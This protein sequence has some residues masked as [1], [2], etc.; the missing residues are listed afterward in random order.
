[1]TPRR[2]FATEIPTGTVVA[3]V[4]LDGVA[5]ARAAT[6]HLKGE[7]P[8][9]LIH[10]TPG[11]GSSDW[12]GPRTIS[13][14]ALFVLVASGT[15]VGACSSSS[16]PA[17]APPDGEDASG[18]ASVIPPPGAAG[19]DASGFLDLGFYPSNIGCGLTESAL[20]AF[21][22]DAGIDLSMLSDVDITN[23]NINGSLDSDA[24]SASVT[25][26]HSMD[27]VA[28]VKMR[29]SNGTI[30]GIYI[31]NSW[32]IEAGATL[33]ITGSS[34]IALVALTDIVVYGSVDVECGG[35]ATGSSGQGQ[36]PGGGAASSNSGTN[37][38]AGGGSFCGTGG[39]GGGSTAN[40]SAYGTGPLVPLLGGSAGGSGIDGGA[41]GGA[42][43]FV[44]GTTITVSGSI[45]APG[46]PG[47][48]GGAGG[49]SGGALLLEAPAV[50][51]SG[52]LATNG[53]GGGSNYDNGGMGGQAGATPAQ[54]GG[55]GSGASGGNGSAAATIAGSPG[56]VN[57]GDV[58]G[59]GGGAGHIRINTM[60]GVATLTGGTLSPSVGTVCVSQGTLSSSAPSCN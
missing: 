55:G 15:W 22:A 54:G 13:P 2:D 59:G 7:L 25:L 26:P 37:I 56:A 33:K 35:A 36:G 46:G 45:S 32:T 51:V 43:Q 1:M 42:A 47:S 49:G 39:A 31:A 60:S 19:T 28:Y 44:A 29:Q 34:P 57:A 18:E 17:I 20:S 52:V 41:G 30:I 3:L 5:L 16:K 11:D 12:S 24:D 9:R 27:T 40:A 53:G 4:T 6:R 23:A 21:A 8:M 48:I 58:G 10:K 50:T 38:G 14:L